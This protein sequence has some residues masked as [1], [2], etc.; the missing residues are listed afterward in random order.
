MEEEAIVSPPTR[1]RAA[2]VA[3]APGGAPLITPAAD[4]D[5]DEDQWPTKNC[6]LKLLICYLGQSVVNQTKLLKF[7]YPTVPGKDM[8]VSDMCA[9]IAA[10]LRKHERRLLPTGLQQQIMIEP[11]GRVSDAVA[12]PNNTPFRCG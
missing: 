4:N 3:A 8:K 9:S 5:N 6:W 11:L 2:A 12:R 1:S 10:G 7:K